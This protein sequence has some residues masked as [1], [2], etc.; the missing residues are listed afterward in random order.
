MNFNDNLNR[1][2]KQKG[3]SQEELA[4]QL[5]VSRQSISKYESGQS[6]P[7]LERL[8]EI[9]DL[10]EVSLDELVGRDYG[11]KQ[12]YVM[13]DQV[14]L[15]NIVR[16]AFTYEYRSELAIKGIPLVHINLGRGFKVAKGI[17]AIGNISLGIIS[18]G[19][20]SL[21][22]F[23]LGGIALGLLAFAG[24][25]LG[26]ISFGGLSIGY[27]AIGGM[28]L[29]VY[30]AGGLAIASKFAVGGMAYG[31]VALGASVKGAHT[32]QTTGVS[33]KVIRTFILHQ[34][35]LNELIVELLLLFIK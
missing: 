14:E 19:G 25:A 31:N 30:A 2:R 17:I 7:E 18:F 5:G 22:I 29:G 3:L 32:L 16:H 6:V 23:S 1:L 24:I 10:F 26:G 20:L 21:G 15:G 12:N 27:L 35:D 4:F 33:A 8:I 13:V 28:S 11:V 9:A 34:N